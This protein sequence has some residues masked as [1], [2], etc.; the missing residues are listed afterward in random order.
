MNQTDFENAYHQFWQILEAE[1]NSGYNPFPYETCAHVETG[2]WWLMSGWMV[3]SELR[4]AINSINAWGMNLLHWATW[5]RVLE[6]KDEQT[7]MELQFHFLDTLVFFCLFQPSRAR[8]VLAKIATHAIHQGNLSVRYSDRDRLDEDELS[9]GQFLGR[10]KSENQLRKL[11]THWQHAPSFIECLTN[12]DSS[13]YRKITRDYRNRASH[14]IAPHFEWG[15]VDFVTRSL[16]PHDELVAQS[17]GAYQLVADPS[18]KVVSYAFG[19][20][21]PLG[22][23]KMY[24]ANLR[25]HELASR[26]LEAYCRLLEEIVQ[27]QCAR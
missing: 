8:D 17:D 2:K 7:S 25:E 20:T 15:E 16:A 27:V 18:R 5:M 11:G 1:P 9:E 3:S 26:A 4:L 22:L 10:K 21:P 24:E 6:G 23:E 13:D 12:V 14:A 19:G